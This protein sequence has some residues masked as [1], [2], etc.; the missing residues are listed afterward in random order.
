MRTTRISAAARRVS[1]LLAAAGLLAACATTPPGAERAATE[2]APRQVEI[3]FVTNRAPD[4]ARDANFGA[5][6]G[7]LSFGIAEIGIP[8]H[9]SIGRHEKPSVFKFEWSPDERKHIALRGIQ[10]LERA[11]FFARLAEAVGASRGRKIMLF[12][13]GYNVD[14]TTASRVLAQFAT[15]LKFDAPVLL[16][17][18]P[19]QGSFTGYTQDATNV[20]WAEPGLTQTIEFVLDRTPVEQVFLIGHSMGARAVTGAY[21]T[22]AAG[23]LFTAQTVDQK[24]ILVA[25][26][27]DAD[28]FRQ[29]IAPHLAASGIHVTV[30]ASSGDRALIASKLFHGYPRAGDSGKGLVI[31]PG[32]E[33]VD[34]SDASG[35][36]LGHSYFAEDRRIME[37]IYAIVQTG[38][39]ADN[40]FG[41]DPVDTAEGRYWTFRR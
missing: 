15:D 28:L 27:I 26:D 11:E 22:I 40:R 30:Y 23:R 14:F 33:T 17:S 5:E 16:F 24:M 36:L 2:T 13:H 25:P 37:D 34:A 3:F 7:E 12:V 1:T 32:V 31:V 21:N 4:L 29:N 19:S 35:G 9:H 20:E 39:S 6:R 8:P 38:Q 10:T 41:L 18:W